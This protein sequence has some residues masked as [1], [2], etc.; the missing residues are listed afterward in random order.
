MN[1]SKY[2]VRTTTKERQ[3]INCG[4]AKLNFISKHRIAR[5]FN[6]KDL[7]FLLEI[8]IS[9]F[10]LPINPNIFSTNSTAKNLIKI[11]KKF[12]TKN[13]QKIIVA[14]SIKQK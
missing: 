3:Q 13:S 1:K 7:S 2:L 10:K 9:N 6:S 14:G 11:L 4:C 8:T 12:K 5:Q